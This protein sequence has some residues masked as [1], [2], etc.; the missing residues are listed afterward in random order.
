MQLE[1]DNFAFV[2]RRDVTAMAMPGGAP[3]DLDWRKAT[4]S[5]SNGAC[6][7]VGAATHT[8]AVRDSTDQAGPQLTYTPAAW[9]RFAQSVR[10][11]RYDI[12][13]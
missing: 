2:N 9:H 3:R 11:G 8:V 4:R 10:Q 12:Q 1:T 6:V 13:R 5:I 7:E